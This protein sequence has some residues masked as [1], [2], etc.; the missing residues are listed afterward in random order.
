MLDLDLPK[1]SL[2]FKQTYFFLPWTCEYAKDKAKY[3]HGAYKVMPEITRKILEQ[4]F[5][6]ICVVI[7]G[8]K[9]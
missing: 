5:G 4:R 3:L 6:M 8:G 7:L 1:L 2:C 9:K